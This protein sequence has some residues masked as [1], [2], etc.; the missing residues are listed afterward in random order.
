MNT[1]LPFSSPVFDA[2]R[3]L[4]VDHL[5]ARAGECLLI[6]TDTAADNQ[7]AWV[8]Q[9]VAES[10]GIRSVVAVIPK[11]P[12]QGKLADPYLPDTVRAAMAESD[13]WVDLTF[14]YIAGS[15][16]HDQATKGG[17]TRCLLAGGIDCEGLVRLYNTVPLDDLFALQTPLDELVAASTGKSCRLTDA[18]GTDVTFTLGKATGSK[19]R[20]AREPGRTYSLPGSVV[21]YPEL[22][23]VR[24][25]IRIVGAMHDYYGALQRPLTIEV[26]NRIQRIVER[27]PDAEL[28]DKALRR[29]GGG[30]YGHVIHF[31]Y[32]IHPGA[33][34]RGTCFVEDIRS[35]GANAIGF[36]RPWWE[37]GGGE[38]HPDGLV[39]RQNL[40]IDDEQVIDNGL[41]CAPTELAQRFRD[42]CRDIAIR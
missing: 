25:S 23:S 7:L 32:G 31:S 38:N 4:V 37:P 20:H 17:R 2:A 26:D 27:G 19:P 39:L 22:E 13:Y 29:A 28:L 41:L 1:T 40:W 6:T 30:D 42:T 36:G 14:P 3:N 34:Y 24:G 9:S 15:D 18:L 11:L 35:L 10:A 21:I 5:A 16:A 12:L 8:L 33:R